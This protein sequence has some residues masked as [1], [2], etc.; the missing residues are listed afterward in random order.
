MENK[1]LRD[2]LLIWVD[3]ETTG[4]DVADNMMGMHKHK[5]IEVGMHITDINFNI[6]DKGFEIVINHKEEDLLNLMNDFVKDMH[7]KSGLLDKIKSSPF[8]LKMA[9]TLMLDYVNSFNIKPQSSPICGN[10]VGFDKNFIDAQMPEFAKMLHYRKID[11]SSIKE[12]VT[13]QYP[14]VA[15]KLEKP[16]KHRGLEDIQDSIR[17]MKFYQ[18]HVFVKNKNKPKMKP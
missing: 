4:L 17:E 14:E 1:I 7:T 13:R 16:Y 3:L 6:I 10:N 5:I 8:S 15:S 18:E 9:E 12:I 2:D 11:V